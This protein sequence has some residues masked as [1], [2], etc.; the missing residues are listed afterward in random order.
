[1]KYPFLYTLIIKK[2][3]KRCTV[4]YKSATVSKTKHDGILGECTMIDWK[5]FCFISEFVALIKST[6]DALTKKS[7]V[8]HVSTS[9]QKHDFQGIFYIFV[10]N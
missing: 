1:M 3:Y 9:M 10:N 6:Y 2:V 5:C 8:N 4:W 7:H